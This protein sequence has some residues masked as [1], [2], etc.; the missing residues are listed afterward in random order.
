MKKYWIGAF[1]L[2]TLACQPEPDELKLYDEL[3]VSTNFDPA[4]DF[5]AYATYAMADDTIGFV[6]N[7]SADTIL[8]HGKSELVRPIISRIKANIDQ[9]GYT[10]VDVKDQPDLGINVMI[11][12]N[13]NLFQQY[14]DPGYYYP[15]Y[16]GY[17]SYYY[18]PY[19]ETYAENTATLVIQIL[20]LK[21]RNANNEVKVVWAAY[22]GDLVSTVN[23]LKQTEEGIDQ[24]FVQ[25]SYFSQ[26]N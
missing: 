19:V 16:Y 8:T 3:V 23:R 4:A 9:R 25:S 7:Q 10:K 13:L 14:V 1:L 6:S 21:N 5:G 15:S 12:N 22:L 20:D 24:A 26:F 11:V 18:Y 17:S 2:L